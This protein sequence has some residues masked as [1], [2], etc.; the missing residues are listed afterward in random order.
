MHR[1]SQKEQEV[2]YCT[3]GNY[4]KISKIFKFLLKFFQKSVKSFF[5][6]PIIN[7]AG[8]EVLL[9]SLLISAAE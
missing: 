8:H 1:M 2:I 9:K 6:S 7:L 4:E 5:Q 3:V